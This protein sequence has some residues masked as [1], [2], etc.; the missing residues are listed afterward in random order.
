MYMKYI[1][2]CHIRSLAGKLLQL[3]EYS[4][5]N[6]EKIKILQ[7]EASSE[8]LPVDADTVCFKCQGTGHTRA[9]IVN[10]EYGDIWGIRYI[11]V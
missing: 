1:P 9:Y 11:C 2:L 4:I 10:P 5:F 8:R 3:T 6:D 7:V